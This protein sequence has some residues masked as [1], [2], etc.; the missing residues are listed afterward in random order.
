M[1]DNEKDLPDPEDFD[2]YED[3]DDF[4]CWACSCGHTQL[5]KPMGQRCP[6]CYGM[7]EEE[8]F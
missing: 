1:E 7:M 6:K 8:Y 3:S 4:N 2:D 5:Q